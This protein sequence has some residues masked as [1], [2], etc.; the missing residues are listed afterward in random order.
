M[1]PGLLKTNLQRHFSTAQNLQVVS[2][3]QSLPQLTAPLYHLFVIHKLTCIVCQKIM[4]RPAIYGAYTEL[5]AGLDPS[6][7]DDDKWGESLHCDVHR[8]SCSV[9]AELLTCASSS[10]PICWPREAE[11]LYCR[12]DPMQTVL[13]LVRGAS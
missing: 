11:P 3:I 5:F 12:G 10:H 6:V 13:G 7:T 1:N 2:F 4:G 9:A 8:L